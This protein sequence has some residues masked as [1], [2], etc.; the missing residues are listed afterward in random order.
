[1]LWT[2]AVVLVILWLLGLMVGYTESVFIHGLSAIAVVL[3]LVSLIQ[4]VNINRK[5][6]YILRNRNYIGPS[7]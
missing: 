5:L 3:L 7:R 6:K 4:E 2:I 1:M